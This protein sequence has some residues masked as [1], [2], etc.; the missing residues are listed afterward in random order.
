MLYHVNER[1][2]LGNSLAWRDLSAL[3]RILDPIP[4]TYN[5]SLCDLC[6]LSFLSLHRPSTILFG[7]PFPFLCQL[8]VYIYPEAQFQLTDQRESL[9]C[10]L[11]WYRIVAI[12]RRIFSWS[13]KSFKSSHHYYQ[14]HIR[15][16]LNRGQETIITHFA[17][18]QQT[19]KDTKSSLIITTALNLFSF[20]CP[21]NLSCYPFT[22]WRVT[23]HWKIP[24]NKWVTQKK[25]HPADRTCAQSLIYFS[26]SSQYG[27]FQLI[28]NHKLTQMSTL[29]II[30]FPSS[31]LDRAH[32][33]W[34]L[35]I[36]VWQSESRSLNTA[37]D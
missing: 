23:C 14:S 32:A 7:V 37:V 2:I 31:S 17:N 22:G 3:T 8:T 26:L 15:F 34:M 33:P 25:S 11:A 20:F 4:S 13:I 29:I 1:L 19:I 6:W 10:I 18:Q 9:N 5:T 35:I 16:E 12:N 28:T 21:L 36:R 30:V 27:L 24:S